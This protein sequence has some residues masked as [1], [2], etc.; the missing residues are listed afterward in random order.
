M[1]LPARRSGYLTTRWDPL[2]V[3]DDLHDE[4]SRLLTNAFPDIGRISVDA[5]S[6]PVEVD[7]TEGAYVI[8][9]DV[10]GVRPDDLSIEVQGNEVRI[11]GRVEEG[12]LR[13]PPRRTGQ[14]DYRLTLP[15]GVDA[16]GGEADLQHGVV[17]LRLPKAEAASRH[18]IPVRGASRAEVGPGEQEEHH[19][20][21]PGEQG[22]HHE[23]EPGE[24]EE[25][26]EG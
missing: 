8:E 18:R 25:H 23:G 24:Q 10:P 7:E 22:E 6:P 26:H 11:M 21:E 4:M 1:P 3:L 15:G 9:A 2:A 16:G 17:R 14:F 19:E 12:T 20:G 5:W 13:H